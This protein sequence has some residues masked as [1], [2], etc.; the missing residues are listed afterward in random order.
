MSIKVPLRLVECFIGS[1]GQRD[2]VPMKMRLSGRMYHL[3][4]QAARWQIQIP[5]TVQGM[6]V[7]RW[8]S[9]P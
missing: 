8:V 1:D 4:D 9:N 7:C 6:G 5:K 3:F 2:E